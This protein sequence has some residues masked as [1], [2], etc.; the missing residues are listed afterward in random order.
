V[1]QGI[2]EYIETE[3]VGMSVLKVVLCLGNPSGISPFFRA[4][5]VDAYFGYLNDPLLTIVD[6]L[7]LRI[8]KPNEAWSTAV[9]GITANYSSERDS[10]R[11]NNPLVQKTGREDAR[12]IG[13]I[14]TYD[15]MP[16][17]WVCV[18]SG[19]SQDPGEGGAALHCTT[20]LL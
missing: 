11:R 2:D 10:A 12:E 17:Q 3:S 4:S 7:L 9:P 8:G 19:D 1:C 14:V 13:R 15:G 5:P 20:A 18:N 6:Q 16:A